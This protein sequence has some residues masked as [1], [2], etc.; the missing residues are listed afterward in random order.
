MQGTFGTF[1]D[2]KVRLYIGPPPRLDVDDDAA[3]ELERAHVLQ[4]NWTGHE[5]LSLNELMGTLVHEAIVS[6]ELKEARR[7]AGL[8]TEYTTT[9]HRKV[10][11]RK[12]DRVYPPPT[13]QEIKEAT[14]AEL[15]RP[16]YMPNPDVCRL[17]RCLPAYGGSDRGDVRRRASMAVGMVR[18]PRPQGTTRRVLRAPP[19]WTEFGRRII[20]LRLMT[21]GIPA[22][23]P[24][25]RRP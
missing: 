20:R 23:R 14:L 17:P 5:D 21:P 9:T 2:N 3:R 6:I 10:K 8:V 25:E 24:S 19:P 12:R 11:K 22:I 16:L 15:D 18:H 4:D 7:T 1:A 13:V